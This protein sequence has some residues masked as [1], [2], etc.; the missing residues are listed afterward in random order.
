MTRAYNLNKTCPKKRKKPSTKSKEHT[1]FRTTSKWKTFRKE[2]LA[3]K[4]YTCEISLFKRKKL[5]QLHHCDPVNYEDLT[6]EKFIVLTAA[7]H[8][9]L[10]RLLSIRDLNIDE[11]CER[12]K[13]AYRRSKEHNDNS[14]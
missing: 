13:D 8:K 9:N 12:L 11:Y 5:L 7:E 2:Q 14:G 3:I 1:K 6:P 10:E 4:N